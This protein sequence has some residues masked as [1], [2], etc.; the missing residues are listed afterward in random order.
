MAKTSLPLWLTVLCAGLGDFRL[1]STQA[2]VYSVNYDGLTVGSF[3][4][5]VDGHGIQLI[6][7][8]GSLL[9]N[10]DFTYGPPSILFIQRSRKTR[11]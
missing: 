4:T 11:Q 7:M 9:E 8:N 2:T 1:G 5:I 3:D 10:N 6:R